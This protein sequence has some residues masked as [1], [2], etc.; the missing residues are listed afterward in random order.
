MKKIFLV[1]LLSLGLSGCTYFDDF[2]PSAS[3]AMTFKVRQVDLEQVVKEN[4][5]MQVRQEIST[6]NPTASVDPEEG[7]GQAGPYRVNTD[8]LNVR[9]EASSESEKVSE[10]AFATEVEILGK[11][12]DES[13]NIWANINFDGG[14]GYVLMEYLSNEKIEEAIARYR[15]VVYV[16]NVRSA[17]NEE[18]EI[19][20]ELGYFDEFDVFASET[21][22]NGKQWLRTV[23]N[24]VE[25]YVISDFCVEIE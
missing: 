20:G 23:Y 22:E 8:I 6:D 12:E 11:V 24:G 1:L 18:A 21:D 19:L 16:V 15:A 5:A 13:G 25:A 10:L 3:Q 7:E 14:N 2:E 17:P 4:P 9:S